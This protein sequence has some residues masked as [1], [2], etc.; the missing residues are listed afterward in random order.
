M[1]SFIIKFCLPWTSNMRML[2][3][4]LETLYTYLCGCFITSYTPAHYYTRQASL[5]LH[6]HNREGW[7]GTVRVVSTANNGASIVREEAWI[8]YHA[9]SPLD[10]I[11][12]RRPTRT[13]PPPPYR[14]GT[15]RK[16]DATCFEIHCLLCTEDETRTTKKK[17]EPHVRHVLLHNIYIYSG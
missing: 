10:S 2:S 12:C 4:V 5:P 14:A 9:P 13:A 15:G 7:D 8:D 6:H 1:Y 3:I 11:T 16:A 17:R